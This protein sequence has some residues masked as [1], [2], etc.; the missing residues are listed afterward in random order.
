MSNEDE[1]KIV[2]MR[3][4]GGCDDDQYAMMFM[5]AMMS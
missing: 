3:M 5:M 1:G 2:M 4:R